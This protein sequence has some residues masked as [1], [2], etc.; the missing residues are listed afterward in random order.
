MRARDRG[1]RAADG[2]GVAVLDGKMLDRPHQ[3]RGTT[4][5]R[6][7]EVVH[8]PEK[9]ESGFRSR[10]PAAVAPNWTSRS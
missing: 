9:W 7:G 1:L 2:K 5:T 10:V 3:A 6:R 8:D 4:N